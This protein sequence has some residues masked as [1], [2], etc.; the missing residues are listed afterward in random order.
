MKMSKSLG[1]TTDPL[2]V[3][4]TNG[5]DIIRL[6]VLSVD[7]TEDHRIGDEILQAA[8][9]TSTASC[10]IPFATLLGALDG[11]RRRPTAMSRW[12]RCPSWSA[13]CWT[14]CWRGWMHD[15]YAQAVSDYFDFNSLRARA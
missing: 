7:Y 10:A 12:R 9:P 2:K 3:M 13:M 8:S 11:F 6:W 4:E 14:V 15:A 1:N 5:A